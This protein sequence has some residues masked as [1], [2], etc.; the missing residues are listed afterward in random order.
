MY[1][2]RRTRSEAVER[3]LQVIRDVCAGLGDA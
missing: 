2:E 1:L 3:A